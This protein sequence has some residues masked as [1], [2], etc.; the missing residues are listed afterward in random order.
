MAH[1]LESF[2][3]SDVGGVP[4]HKL[5]TK[6]RGLQTVDAMLEAASADFDVQLVKVAAVDDDGNLITNP[7]GTPVIIDDSRATIRANADGSYNDLATVGTR[8]EVRQ[9]REVAERALAVIGASN[10]DAVVDTCGVLRDGRRFFMTIE[11]G[12]VVV[13]PAGINDRIARYLVVSSGHDGVWPIRYA[14][15]DIRGVCNNT[16]VLGLKSAER[17][18]TARHTRNVDTALEDAQEV[19]RLST[20]WSRAFTAEAERLLRVPVP[21]AGDLAKIVGKAFP[22]DSTATDRQKKNHEIVRDS[23]IAIYSN[24]RNAGGYGR[25]GWAAYNAVA[26]YLDHHRPS[27]PEDRAVASMDENSWVTRTKRLAHQAIL[28][29]A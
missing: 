1:E 6:M 7:D 10:G 25:N 22:L 5:G 8:Y 15:T 2:A 11:L 13:D 21:T 20:S 4:W 17:V 26:E 3:F 27:Q 9:N 23:I 19:L 12:A 28:G 24:E 14:N 29:A 16:V 18:F